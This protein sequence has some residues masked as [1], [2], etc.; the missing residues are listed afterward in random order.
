MYQPDHF[1]IIVPGIQ[2]MG[3]ASE[4]FYEPC[5]AKKRL[6]SHSDFYKILMPVNDYIYLPYT[7]NREY[8]IILILHLGGSMVLSENSFDNAIT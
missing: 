8:F 7:L 2:T 6:I 5:Q 4:E 1:P 3:E